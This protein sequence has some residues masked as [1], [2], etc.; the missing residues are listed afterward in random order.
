MNAEPE[1]T[2]KNICDFLSLVEAHGTASIENLL[3]YLKTSTWKQ[4]RPHGGLLLAEILMLGGVTRA[5]LAKF[6]KRGRSFAAING[7]R[8]HLHALLQVVG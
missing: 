8:A 4:E 6:S 2:C 1:K 7:L 5:E 3:P